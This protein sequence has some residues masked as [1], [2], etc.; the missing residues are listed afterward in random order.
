[1]QG[2]ARYFR[3]GQTITLNVVRAGR[4]LAVSI[5]LISWSELKKLKIT[6]VAL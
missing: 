5:T 3:P 2:N 1:L 4:S 6:A